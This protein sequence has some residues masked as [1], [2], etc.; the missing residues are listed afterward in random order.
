LGFIGGLVLSILSFGI[1]GSFR[2]YSEGLIAALICPL[3]VTFIGSFL[4]YLNALAPER[5]ETRQLTALN[6]SIASNPNALRDLI[7]A[8][9]TR[10]L[11]SGERV[12]IAERAWAKNGLPDDELPF[13][14]S[15]FADDDSVISGIIFRQNVT[16]DEIRAAY[17]KYKDNPRFTTVVNQ[18]S[19]NPAT[20]KDIIA[21]IEKGWPHSRP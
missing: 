19:K 3:A 4:F 1:V 11:S 9:R 5:A 13:L 12:A 8:A 10:T 21:E 6:S 17:E 20:P 15:Y 2:S 16:P 7:E 18:I 14:L